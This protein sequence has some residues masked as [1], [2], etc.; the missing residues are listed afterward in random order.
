MKLAPKARI[1]HAAAANRIAAA[2]EYWSPG[3]LA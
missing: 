3:H 2:P 1:E